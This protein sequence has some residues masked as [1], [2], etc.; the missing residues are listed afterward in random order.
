MKIILNIYYNY[1]YLN[2]YKNNNKIL[3]LMRVKNDFN[4]GITFSLFAVNYRE[5]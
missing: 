1:L 4:I 2:S 5:V 3:Y